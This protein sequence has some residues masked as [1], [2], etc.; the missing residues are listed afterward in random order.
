MCGGGGT[1]E[2]LSGSKERFPS[3][4]GSVPT[5]GLRTSSQGPALSAPASPLLLPAPPFR[6]ACPQP[7]EAPSRA[8]WPKMGVLHNWTSANP[9]SRGISGKCCGSPGSLQAGKGAAASL[10]PSPAPPRQKVRSC[11][12]GAGEKADP[13]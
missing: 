7:K 3:Q 1:L 13:A 12:S 9:T 11:W 5:L 2:G 8:P 10:P 6:C 4:Q